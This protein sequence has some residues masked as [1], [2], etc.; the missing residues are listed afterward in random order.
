MIGNVLKSD[1]DRYASEIRRSSRLLALAKSGGLTPAMVGRY[2][3]GIA[4]L[5]ERTQ[6][7]LRLARDLAAE[8]GAKELARYFDQKV[9]EEAGHEEWAHSDLDH[10]DSHYGEPMPREPAPGILSLVRAIEDG[11]RRDPHVYLA[12]TFFAEYVTVTLG[13]EW[14][15]A[16][17]EAC[18]VPRQ[19]MTVQTRH[20]ELDKK[21]AADGAVEIDEL[22]DEDG[23]DALRAMLSRT[24]TLFSEFCDDVCAHAA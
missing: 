22:V 9:E 16:L 24:M 23:V 2:F 12:Y 7:H 21:H 18:G 3:S 11:I 1:I 15:A 17:E 13:P 5:I 10:L 20:I 6:T 19:G 4:Y 14:V 8:R